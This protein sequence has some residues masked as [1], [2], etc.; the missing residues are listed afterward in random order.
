MNQG[1]S[2]GPL[3]DRN[4]RVIGV[5]TMVYSPDIGAPHAF[6]IRAD[7]LLEPDQWVCCPDGRVLLSKVA[8]N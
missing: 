3:L 7:L 1:N 6:S 4:V 8:R 2:G 5:N